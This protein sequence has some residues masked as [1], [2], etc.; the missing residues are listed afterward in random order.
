MTKM[1]RTF[2]ELDHVGDELIAVA[3][4][5]QNELMLTRM[6]LECLAERRDMTGERVFFD[7]RLGPDEFQQ[8]VLIDYPLTMLD[9]DGEDLESLG[10]ERNERLIPPQQTA[11]PIDN[12]GTESIPAPGGM[13]AV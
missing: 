1:S 3:G 10:G 9:E 2:G 11:S 5:G 6:L 7:G 12:V 8:L 13:R 4:H